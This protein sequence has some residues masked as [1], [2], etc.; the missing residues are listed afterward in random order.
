MAS[1]E[2]H[3]SWLGR[4]A[5][6]ISLAD[7]LFRVVVSLGIGAAMRGWLDV[8]LGL[9]ILGGAGSL[10]LLMAFGYLWHLSK[11]NHEEFQRSGDSKHKPA[12]LNGFEALPDGLGPL[13]VAALQEILEKD[14][15]LE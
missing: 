6:T 14:G 4:V 15:V 9:S 13:Y 11:K 1:R 2:R 12:R 3:W 5:D 10:F 8:P 7:F